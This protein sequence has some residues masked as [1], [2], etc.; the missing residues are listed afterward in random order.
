MS[1]NLSINASLG[2]TE[3]ASSTEKKNIKIKINNQNPEE[4]F[5]IKW[6]GEYFHHSIL[7]CLFLDPP[8]LSSPWWGLPST[9]GFHF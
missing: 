1:R 5:H 9:S 4:V 3:I 8:P 7:N 2:Q 6:V